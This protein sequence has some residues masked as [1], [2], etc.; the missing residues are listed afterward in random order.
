M[1]K[2][3]FGNLSANLRCHIV[4]DL[5]DICE[6]KGIICM[7]KHGKEN[8]WHMPFRRLLYNNEQINT[9]ENIYRMGMDFG[10]QEVDDVIYWMEMGKSKNLYCQTS[11]YSHGE[12][13]LW[14]LHEA[15]LERKSPS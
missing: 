10:F 7:V 5:Y 1:I 13:D 4:P 2:L 14:S 12:S 3:G 11:L 15:Y 6:N 9:W 8:D